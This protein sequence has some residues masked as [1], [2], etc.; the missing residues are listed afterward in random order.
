M[1]SKKVEIVGFFRALVFRADQE[2][3]WSQ[4][5]W[6][7]AMSEESRTEIES[8]LRKKTAEGDSHA[9]ERLFSAVYTELRAMAQ[10]LME[11]ERT[12]HT[13]QATRPRQRGM[14]QTFLRFDRL[15]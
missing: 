1:G 12:G 11:D 6:G 2:R 5:I 15:L 9:K 3:T 7:Y 8:L 14:N 13:L 4:E 10:N